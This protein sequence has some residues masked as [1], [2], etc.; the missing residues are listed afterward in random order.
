LIVHSDRGSQYA[1]AAY[2]AELETHGMLASMSGKGNCYEAL[3][4]FVWVDL[5]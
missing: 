1:S 4:D 5:G 3:R 2:R